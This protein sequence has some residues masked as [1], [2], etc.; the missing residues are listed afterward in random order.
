MKGF[1]SATAN[2]TV[3]SVTAGNRTL[4]VDFPRYLL[5]AF[6]CGGELEQD[7]PTSS[8][9][10]PMTSDS[11]EGDFDSGSSAFPEGMAPKRQPEG[12]RLGSGVAG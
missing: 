5:C 7:P 4:R 8:W 6:E 3:N 10:R 1:I 11:R 2:F 9:P 12:C